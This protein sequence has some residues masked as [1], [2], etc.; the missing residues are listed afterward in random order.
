MA[1]SR[2]RVGARRL[3]R[4]E[5]RLERRLKASGLA[6]LRQKRGYSFLEGGCKGDGTGRGL[7]GEVRYSELEGVVGSEMLGMA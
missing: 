4:L 6:K 2:L 3:R 5:W 1:K 7:R